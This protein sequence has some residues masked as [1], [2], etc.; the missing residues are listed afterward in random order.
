MLR[1]AKIRITLT[2]SSLVGQTLISLPLADSVFDTLNN[3][4]N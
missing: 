4:R 2:D 1:V 3:N